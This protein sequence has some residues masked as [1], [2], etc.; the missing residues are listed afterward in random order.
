M[1]LCV[2]LVDDLNRP[3]FHEQLHRQLQGA[4]G[5]GQL[6]Q[7][8]NLNPIHLVLLDYQAVW[9]SPRPRI[10]HCLL[11]RYFTIYSEG[12]VPNIGTRIMHLLV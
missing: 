8:F 3:C 12:L 1:A 2:Q 10:T 4:K 6:T 7:N 9:S 5:H 11:N